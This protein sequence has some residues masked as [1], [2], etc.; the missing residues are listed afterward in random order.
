M[1]S[2]RGLAYFRNIRVMAARVRTI[3]RYRNTTVS[4][5]WGTKRNRRRWRGGSVKSSV[6]T[7]PVVAH[8]FNPSTQEAEAGGFL[9]SRPAWSTK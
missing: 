6:C 8:A 4:L 7:R 1:S 3:K 5:A 9:S 2:D